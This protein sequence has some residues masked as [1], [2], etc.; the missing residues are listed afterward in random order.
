MQGITNPLVVLPVAPPQPLPG[1][2]MVGRKELLSH[3][4]DSKLLETGTLP[5]C[6]LQNPPADGNA[7]W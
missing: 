5:S 3:Q 4:P 6:S 7:Y 1:M 2:S